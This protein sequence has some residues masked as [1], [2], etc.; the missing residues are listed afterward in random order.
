MILT[1]PEPMRPSEGTFGSLL[2]SKRSSGQCRKLTSLAGKL[3]R[4]RS[5][6]SQVLSQAMLGRKDFRTREVAVILKKGLGCPEVKKFPHW[7]R[8][9][10][11]HIYYEPREE[12]LHQVSP[13][14]YSHREGF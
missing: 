6:A 7:V 5:E 12:N 1:S 13:K 9:S 8:E 10:P 4:V 3:W 2:P 14:F 11:V